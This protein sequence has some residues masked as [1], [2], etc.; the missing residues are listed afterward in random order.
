MTLTARLTRFFVRHVL[1]RWLFGPDV[2]TM[3]RRERAVRLPSSAKVT[4]VDAGGVPGQWV[5]PAGASDRVLLYLHGGGFV[6]CSPRTHQGLAHGIARASSA[7]ALMPA[8]R[9][10]PEHP[11]PAALDDCVASYRWLLGQGISPRCIAIAGDSAGGNLALAT[12]LALKE[13]GDPLPAAA[14]TLAPVSDFTFPLEPEALRREVLLHPEF[15]LGVPAWYLGAADASSPRVSPA[16][17]DLRGLPPLLI[18]AGSEELLVGDNRRLAEVARAA[19]V[20]VTLKVWDGFWHVF[21]LFDWVPEARLA[22]REIGA[23]L[24]ERLER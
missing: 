15:L 10:A 24:H 21:Q 17:G 19:G 4:P 7:R 14:A 18:H 6:I 23:F 13:A 2:A 9:L 5:E 8:Y 20:D 12:L 3:R 11:F 16:L 1:R 22:V